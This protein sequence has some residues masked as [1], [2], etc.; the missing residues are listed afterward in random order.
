MQRPHEVVF[1]IGPLHRQQVM[2][3]GQRLVSWAEQEEAGLLVEGYGRKQHF[4]ALTIVGVFF[5]TF[6][7]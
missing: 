1:G 6:Q 7:L 3:M 5:I 2:L 4:H